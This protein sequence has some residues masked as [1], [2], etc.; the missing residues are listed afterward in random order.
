[1]IIGLCRAI[2]EQS[3]SADSALTQAPNKRRCP[4]AAGVRVTEGDVELLADFGLRLG[5]ER[6]PRDKRL[7]EGLRAGRT[8][9]LGAVSEAEVA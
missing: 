9:R 3:M 1:M 7:R 8:G 6:N 4:F 2:D 5:W